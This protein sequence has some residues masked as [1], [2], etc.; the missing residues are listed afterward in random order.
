MLAFYAWTDTSIINMLNTKVSY[1]CEE[2]ADLFIL[3]LARVSSD[4]VMLVMQSNVFSNVYIIEE[5]KLNLKGFKDVSFSRK[6]IEVF[7]GHR[8]KRMI[9]SCLKKTID[10]RKYSILF[11]GAFWSLTLYFFWYFKKQNPTIKIRFVEE[12]LASYNSPNNWKYRCIPEQGKREAL[13]RL[14]WYF[15]IWHFAKRAIDG[16]YL[17]APD[18]KRT[19]KERQTFPLPYIGKDGTCRDVIIKLSKTIDMKEYAL[20]R[21]FFLTDMVELEKFSCD[22]DKIVKTVTTIVPSDM[23]TLKKHPALKEFFINVPQDVYIDRRNYFF[24][25]G[26]AG[27]DINNKIFLLRNSS[28]S[29]TVKTFLNKEP[30]IV[31]T[32][33]LYPDNDVNN[34]KAM[35]EFTSDLRRCYQKPERIYAPETTEELGRI[36]TALITDQKSELYITGEKV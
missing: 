7:S 36:L 1:F 27:L 18:F 13:M 8:Y 31:F 14:F 24:E 9:Y 5:P 19:N 22:F 35:D 17:Y 16:E 30:Y 20:R 26:C 11:T 2:P 6:L 4:L 28:L 21:L 25:A 23:L 3:K 29:L 33:K 32:Y 10:N 12:G 34:I 15:P